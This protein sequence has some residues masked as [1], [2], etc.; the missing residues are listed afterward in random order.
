MI[1]ETEISIISENS[2]LEGKIQFNSITRVHGVIHGD[3]FSSPGSTLILAESSMTEGNIQ[4]DTLMISGFVKGD[5][6]ASQQVILSPT[7]RVAG[8]IESP[9]LVME[10]GAR[11]EGKCKTTLSNRSRSKS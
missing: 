11:F 1:E 2:R 8:T 4:A 5:I 6:K 9:S 7:A 10:F 3:I